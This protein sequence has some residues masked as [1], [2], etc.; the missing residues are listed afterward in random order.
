MRGDG[1]I[2]KRGDVFWSYYKGER[3]SLDTRDEKQARKLH[4]KRRDRYGRGLDISAKVER[5]GFDD[6]ASATTP[7]TASGR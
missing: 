3:V 2:Y 4:Q 1:F 5:T 7:L 6:L